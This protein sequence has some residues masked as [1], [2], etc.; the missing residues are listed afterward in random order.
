MTPTYKLY[1][2]KLSITRVNEEGTEECAAQLDVFSEYEVTENGLKTVGES[3]GFHAQIDQ[4]LK[5]IESSNGLTE[6]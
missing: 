6:L 5:D 2:D 1:L 4:Y 3:L